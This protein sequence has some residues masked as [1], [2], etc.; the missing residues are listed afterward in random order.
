M[1]A[2]RGR[3]RIVVERH[4]VRAGDG[5]PGETRRA[6]LRGRQRGQR[7]RWDTDAE[8]EGTCVAGCRGTPEAPY[9]EDPAA[10]CWVSRVFTLCIKRCDPLEPDCPMADDL[11]IPSDP[12][13]PR[14][15][16]A[17]SAW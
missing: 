1:H 13:P 17:A 8:N 12:A 4:E 15:C 6:V 16:A 7:D 9:C 3:R 5:G 14:R 10:D 11:C 2:V